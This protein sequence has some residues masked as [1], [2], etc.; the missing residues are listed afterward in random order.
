MQNVQAKM[1]QIEEIRSIR[2]RQVQQKRILLGCK[3]E[4]RRQEAESIIAENL[5]VV[6]ELD[7]MHKKQKQVYL[8]HNILKSVRLYYACAPISVMLSILMP[9]PPNNFFFRR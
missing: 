1:R 2:D 6:Q 7:Q 4:E 5:R 9:L 8:S 3:N